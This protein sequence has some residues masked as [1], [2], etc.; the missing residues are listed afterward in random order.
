MK[1]PLLIFCFAL[2]FFSCAE[3]KEAK[4]IPLTTKSK[5]A[6]ELYAKA[7][8]HYDQLETFEANQYFRKAIELDSNF[9]LAKIYYDNKLD[10]SSNRKRL[11]EA[12]NNRATLSEM[13]SVIVATEYEQ[14]IN[15]D[16]L[17]ADLM[18]DSLINKHPDYYELYLYSADIKND[19]NKMDECLKRY[20]ETLDVNPNSYAAAL[21]IPN[22]HSPSGS[23]NGKNRMLPIDKRDLNEAEKYFKIAEKIRPTAPATSRMYG[24][25]YRGKGELDKALEKYEESI[26]LNIDKTSLLGLSYM[27]VGHVYLAKSEYEKSREYYKK[28]S[29]FYEK[30]NEKNGVSNFSDRVIITYLYEKKYDESILESNKELQRI[31]SLHDNEY[32]KNLLRAKVENLKFITYGH[33]L[34]EEEALAS[35]KAINNYY[36]QTKSVDI[37][38]AS[39]KNEILSIEN[40]AKTIELNYA[41][42]YNILF[43]HYEE[44]EKILKEFETLSTSLLKKNPT[45]MEDFYKVSGY[46]NLMEGKVNESIEFYN[47]VVKRLDEDPYNY[48]FFALALKANGNKVDSDNIFKKVA[49][50]NF[51]TWQCAIVK[52][53]AKN[54]LNAGN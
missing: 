6:A 15:K 21:S 50:N 3:K 8:F 43:A 33:S 23:G 53:L 42:Y 36:A 11:I 44:A 52:N 24:N 39:D 38:K 41:L 10:P 49:N 5:E 25:L 20:K 29:E 31:D 14:Q 12:Y 1:N 13:E 7:I 54:Q 16:V 30:L 45:A 27:M 40:T 26:K 46:L 28:S 48:Y 4:R 18:I 51:V 32:N 37:Q 17:R 47:K 22:L 34:K 9:A 2:M 35:I 19:L